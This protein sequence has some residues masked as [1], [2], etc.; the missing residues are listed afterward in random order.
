MK[1]KY[2]YLVILILIMSLIY[3]P[4]HATTPVISDY[5]AYPPF[6]STNTTPNLLLII[7]NSGSM[8]DLAYIDEGNEPTRSSNYCYDQTYI[9]ATT[10]TGYFD[11]DTVYSYDFTD[12][13]FEVSSFTVMCSHELSGQLCVNIVPG[14]PDTVNEFSARGN[15]LNW[16]TA[17]KL[18]VQKKILTGGKYNTSTNELTSETRGCVGRRFLKEPLTADY[19]EG[20]TNTSLG[21]LLGIAGPENEYNPSGTSN[22]GQ[23]YI[24][25]YVGDYNEDLCQDAI[26]AVENHNNPSSIRTSVEDCI[27]YEDSGSQY[28]YLSPSTS[29]TVDSDCDTVGELGDCTDV[30]P[31]KNRTCTS[32]ASMIGLACIDDADCNTIGSSTGPCVGGSDTPVNSTKVVFAHS[33]QECW[34]IWD[35]K[36]TEVGHDAWSADSPKCADIY[37]NY[38]ICN[39]GDDDG[40]ECTSDA[41]C[42]GAGTCINGTDAIRAGNA[43]LMCSS[44]YVGYC[45]TTSDSW[46]TTTW[47][48]KEYSLDGDVG[49]NCFRTKYTEFCNAVNIPPAIDPSDEPSASADLANIPA[50]IADIGVAAQLGSPIAA[51]KAN[52]YDTTTPT[53]LLNDFGDLIR[54]GAMSFN[55]DGS[56]YE[57]GLSSTDNLNCPKLCSATTTLSCYSDVDC[58]T[59][60]TCESAS[61]SS[62]AGQII[63]YVGEGNCSSTTSTTCVRDDQCPGVETCEATV[64]DHSTG[65]IKS[66]DDITAN[67]WTPI[68]EAYYN[69]LAYFVSDATD[70]PDLTAADYTASVEAISTALN[71]SDFDSNKNP[72]EFTCQSNNILIISDGAPTA[73][74]HPTMTNIAS[75]ALYNDSDTIDSSSCGNYSG[76]SYLDDLSF[77]A[78]NRNIF[79]PT[80]SVTYDN[81]AA[82][83]ITTYVVYTGSDTSTETDECAPRTLMENTAEN[84]GT[85]LYTAEEPSE[86]NSALMTAFQEVASGSASGTAVSVL[87]T[88]GE[89][90]GA[91]YQAYFLPEKLEGAEARKWLG[92]IKAMFVDSYGNLRE[93]TNSNS[94]LDLTSDLILDITYSPTTGT[95][96]Y[97][98]LDANGDGTRDSATPESSTT[99]DNVNAIWNGGKLLWQTAPSS[100]TIYTSIDG[101]TSIDF[102]TLNA[103]PLMPYLRAAN[104]TESSNIISWI[105]GDDL[106][107]ITDSGHADGYRERSITINGTSNVWKLGDIVHSTPMVVSRPSEN[108]DLLYGDATYSNF[109]AA[110][111]TRRTMVYTGANDGMI[112]AFN[113]GCYDAINHKFYSDVDVNGDCT[114]G[115]HSLGEEL[116]S[117]IPRGLLPH[118]SWTTQ[119]DYTHVY[120]VDLVPKITDADIFTADSTHTNGWGTILIGGFRYGGKDISWTSAGTAYSAS[121]EYFALDIT[122]PLNPRLLWTFSDPG[123]GLSMSKPAIARLDGKTYMLIGS[124]PTDYDSSSNFNAYQSGNVYALNISSGTNGIISTW[125]ENSN[126]WKIPTGNTSSFMADP[127]SVDVDMDFDVDVIYIGEN[128]NDPSIGAW[129]GLMQ[130]ITTNS[131]AQTDPSLWTLSTLAN[132]DSISGTNDIIK[133]ITSTPSVAMD[134]RANLFVYFGTGQFYGSAD[135]NQTDTGAFYAIKDGCWRGGCTTSYSSLLDIST[136]TV[137]VDGNVS[138][139][140]G[141]CAG[142][143]STWPDLSATAYNCDGWAMYFGN[144]GESIDFT[145]EILTHT[146]ERMLSKPLVIGGLVLWATY[147][148]GTDICSHEG[149][150]NV[151]A[152]YYSTGT[153][154]TNYVFKE[155]QDQSDPSPTVARVKKFGKGMPSSISAQITAG[156]T[157]KG[158]VQ[159]STGSILEVEGITPFTLKSAPMGWKNKELD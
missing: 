51:L 110:H 20:G 99:L 113:G 138:G 124:G 93:D 79:D 27:S 88:T 71:A 134:Y 39:G 62:D 57:C 115:T 43:A 116:W 104:S 151:Y 120:Y 42:S 142:A 130:R 69:G 123:L 85:T 44:T 1:S 60:E 3:I 34:Q 33:M 37:E 63:H 48:D 145:G 105:R 26:E 139:I 157:A 131:G 8:Y 15:Y 126:F 4:V 52:S 67:T 114:S 159:K 135:R 118:L 55:F 100:R 54:F 101:Y 127:V 6:V 141:S 94:A 86:L 72:I 136:A 38:K 17:S 19:V 13:R 144:L 47:D 80:D 89:G 36:T 112:H 29:C 153:S 70:N 152:V 121:P 103:S 30:N 107:G 59:G 68:A 32:P 78:R 41:D 10:Y 2:T 132:I 102:S 90:E 111:R 147:I 35:G 81:D 82:Q 128:Y 108:F 45:A 154:F 5:T 149:E 53:G 66:I 21:I 117:F 77:Y 137:D 106:A 31:K 140:S 119:P 14:S 109:R 64:G 91:V 156:G 16:L 146:G 61:G 133:K 148:P 18:D 97:K 129:N 155:Q 25:V 28:C 24:H 73:D 87:S 76:S 7:D 22:G 122:D 9:S 58:P 56:D 23:T 40:S 96:V 92:Y 83:R 125:T 12:N 46:A 98:Y 158:F 95:I 143:V 150:S 50:I 65:L 84:G 49:E 75:Q 74:I 11:A